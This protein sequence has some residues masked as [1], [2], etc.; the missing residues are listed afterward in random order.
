MYKVNFPFYIARRYLLGK[1]S[2]NAIN[3]ISAI[4]VFG[5]ATGT[6]ALVIVLSVFNGFDSVV[7]SLFSTWMYRVAL[8]TALNRTSKPAF[9][10]EGPKAHE[11]GYDPGE[12]Y[13]LSE[14]IRLLH[15]AISQLK[16]IDRAIILLW[17]EELSYKEIAETIGITE[18]NVSVRIVRIKHRLAEIIKKLQ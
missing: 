18:K 3:I 12:D 1:K 4:S 2:R 10:S 14:E 16:K 8:N 13:D 17:L 11:I 7:K 6:M 15:K 5:V 9:L